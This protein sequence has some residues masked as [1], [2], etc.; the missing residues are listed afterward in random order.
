M[1]ALLANATLDVHHAVAIALIASNALAGVWA[2]AAQRYT[3]LR[4]W[5]LWITIAVAQATT[6][7][8]AI[9]GTILINRD[10]LKPALVQVA[11][12]L[13]R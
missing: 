7:V 4:G 11:R 6:F 13:R 1:I 9:T 2:L 10:D 3:V 12:L 5:P 8:E